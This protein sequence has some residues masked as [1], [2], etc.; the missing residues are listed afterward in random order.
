MIYLDHAASTRPYP[1]VAAYLSEHLLT[2]YGN[3]AALHAYGLSQEHILRE[4]KQ[5]LAQD[6]HTRP[7]NLILTSGATEAANTAIRAVCRSRSHQGRHI[8]FGAGDHPATSQ[9]CHELKQEQ[10]EPEAIPLLANGKPDLDAMRRQLRPDTIL[11][12]LLAVNNET[13]AITDLALADQIRQKVAPQALLYVDYV[14][15][16]TK[17]NLNLDTSPADYAAFAGHKIHAPKGIGLLYVAPKRPFSP[18]IFGG[19]QQQGRRSGTENP[20]L[21]KALA[22]ACHIG[23]SQL[24]EN[25]QVVSQLNQRLRQDLADLPVQFNSPDDALPNIL[26]LSLANSKGE[27]LLHILARQGIYLSTTSACHSAASTGSSV[28][29]SMGISGDR[30]QGALR[31]SLDASNTPA[32]IDTAAQAIHEAW[33][34]LQQIN[35]RG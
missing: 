26:N 6:L 17:L 10:F 19:G 21:A 13:G 25:Q 2:D 3:P 32:E 34:W 31:I 16:W 4:A 28:L 12:C 7:E 15:A 23:S 24:A 18:L 8:L 1:E 22:I 35:L 27:T 14:Q 9:L 30:L 5:E 29:S 33:T 11:I 20:I